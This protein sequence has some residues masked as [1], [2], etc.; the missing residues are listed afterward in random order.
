MD[1]ISSDEKRFCIF[2]PNSIL[3]TRYTGKIFGYYYS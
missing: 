1:Y 2:V 3:E